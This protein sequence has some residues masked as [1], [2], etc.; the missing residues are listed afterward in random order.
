MT[1]EIPPLPFE[2]PVGERLVVKGWSWEVAAMRKR[3]L[4]DFLAELAHAEEA[5]ASSQQGR[6]R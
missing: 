1:A 3:A 2:V 5:Q 4:T 6:G